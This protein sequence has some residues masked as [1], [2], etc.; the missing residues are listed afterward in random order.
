MLELPARRTVYVG[1][2]CSSRFVS[3]KHVG[4]T[5]VDV[6]KFTQEAVT[7]LGPKPRECVGGEYR[8]VVLTPHRAC[9][10][11]PLKLEPAVEH[12]VA[13]AKGD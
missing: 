6:T 3:R 12:V 4:Q 11:N 5:E 1:K 10:L 8:T 13:N 9:E 7:V 2:I